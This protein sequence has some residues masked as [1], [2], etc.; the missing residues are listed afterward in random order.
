MK[1]LTVDAVISNLDNAV[2]FVVVEAEKL[3][4]NAIC[5]NRIRLSCEELFVNIINYAYP[6]KTGS[7]EISCDET[8]EKKGLRIE[9]AD[10]G[11]AFDP[12]SCAPEDT[13][14][15]PIEQRTIGG[16]GIHLVRMV[17]SG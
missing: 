3:G 15:L 4:F 14:K 5:L 13:T 16:L 8:G 6:D 12:L 17:M 7:I 9:I 2:D 10:S 11:I 1:K